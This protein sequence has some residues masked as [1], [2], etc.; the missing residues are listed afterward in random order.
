M[1]RLLLPPGD[2]AAYLLD[3]DGTIADSMP[4]HYLAWRGALAEWRCTFT[5]ERFYAW[6]GMPP[7]VIVERLAAEQGLSIPA[8]RVA[9]RKEELYLE[10]LPRLRAV[11]EVLEH[12][13]AARGRVPMA[14]VSGSPRDSVVATLGGL[15]L[16]DAFDTLV[17]A[18]DYAHG[19][20]HPEP[21]LTA[22]ARLGVDPRACLVFEDSD[23]GIEAA[24]AAG[25]AAVR[26]PPPWARGAPVRRAPLSRWYQ[27]A[28][29]KRE[30][31]SPVASSSSR[32][33]TSSPST[34]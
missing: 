21:F 33:A 8:D 11:A 22:A 26:V 16:L 1:A 19:K 32:S 4:L 30:A 6:G 14:V 29:L 28:L 24:A 13:I 20:P 31:S 17:C 3:C 15:G 25:M 9:L 2:F 10:L 12:V 23:L 5:E 27:S 34:P 7:V 18:G